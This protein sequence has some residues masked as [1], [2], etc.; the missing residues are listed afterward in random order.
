MAR[1]WRG[2]A[3]IGAVMIP[4]MLYVSHEHQLEDPRASI[5]G[6]LGW[7]LSLFVC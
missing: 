6:L 5:R 1:A 7:L 3:F 4:T 2:V